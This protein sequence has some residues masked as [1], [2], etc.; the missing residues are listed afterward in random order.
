MKT[1]RFLALAC[2]VLLGVVSCKKKFDIDKMSID[3]TKLETFFERYPE[4]ADYED[5]ITDLYEKHQNHFIWYDD[6]GRVDFAEVLY[7]RAGQMGSEGVVTKLPYRDKIAA[8]YELDEKKKPETDNDLLISG[9][10]FF[11]TSKVLEGL[12]ADKSKQ[13]GWYLP[14]EKGAYVDYLDQLMKDP[15]LIKKDEKEL[16]GQYYNLRK[17]LQ[18]YREIQKKGGW[19]TINWPEGRKSF[20]PG[21]NAPEIAQIR[22]RLAITGDLATD[23]KSTIFDESLKAGLAQYEQRQGRT[24]DNVVTPALVKELNVPV[25]ARIKTIVV[26]MERCRWIDPD[27]TDSK[28]LIAVNIPSYRLVYFR[29]GKPVLESN[30]VVGKELNKTVVFSGKMSYLVFSPY[31]NIPPSI[32]KKE[33]QPG[34]DADPDYL[35]KHNMEWNNG[36]VRQKPGD[37]NSLGLVKFMFPNSNNIYLHDTPA[38]SL[39]SKDSR[40]FSHGCVRVEKARDL[41]VRILDGDKNWTPQKIDEAMHAGKESQYALKRK[42]PVYIAYFTAR[43]DENGNVSFFE[44]V[45]QRD[46]RLAHLLYTE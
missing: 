10:Y 35:E 2:F 25:A 21:D 4:F 42:I 40:A 7:N 34:I 30:V 36:Q 15:D 46:D 41:A 18:R 37:N 24:P 23:S 12:D 11:Y 44:D 6:S 22:R 38:K 17:G 29:E 19:G 39:F 33:I 8:I 26:N 27:I 14:R 3:D 20:K 16:I 9:M 28:E 1:L 43:A 32:I 45:Y 31:W 13:T 5:Q